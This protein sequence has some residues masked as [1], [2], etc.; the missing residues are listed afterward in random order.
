M[1]LSLRHITAISEPVPEIHHR[2]ISE[3]DFEI[4]YHRAFREPLFEMHHR[5]IIKPLLKTYHTAITEPLIE[6]YV[7]EQSLLVPPDDTDTSC[8]APGHEQ[9]M[10]VPV[11]RR[12]A[13]NVGGDMFHF[14][15]S[16]PQ[17][18]GI[19]GLRIT[20]SL[21]TLLPA[22]KTPGRARRRRYPACRRQRLLFI[23]D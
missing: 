12:A 17:A 5:A 15:P 16:P 8:R 4:Y 1:N 3:P 10:Q 23:L 9:L 20:Y 11:W 13:H 19:V 18:P 2:A 14:P 6:L 21:S 7:T 22:Q